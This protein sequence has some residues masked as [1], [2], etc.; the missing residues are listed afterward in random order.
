M[1]PSVSSKLNA[2]KKILRVWAELM[3]PNT[4]GLPGSRLFMAAGE[5]QEESL[6]GGLSRSCSEAEA[7]VSRTKTAFA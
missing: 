2:T 3:G 6:H 4:A 5:W 1:T 7:R